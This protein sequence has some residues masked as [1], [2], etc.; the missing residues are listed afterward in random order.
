MSP[1]SAIG[2][3]DA[4]DAGAVNSLGVVL[5]ASAVMR[6]VAILE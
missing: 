5:D 4:S 1:C 2:E 6:A 3:V